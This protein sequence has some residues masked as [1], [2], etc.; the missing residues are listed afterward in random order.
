MPAILPS[1]SRV[2]P[3]RRIGT[4][5]ITRRLQF[6]L[7]AMALVAL[8]CALAATSCSTGL[9]ITVEPGYTSLEIDGDLGLTPS[10]GPTTPQ[11]IDIQEGFGLRESM[12]SP[13]GRVEVQAM[14]A[15]LQLS[16]FQIDQTGQGNL[17]VQFGDIPISTPIESTL[18]MTNLKAEV[19]FDL[20]DIG[21][22]RISPGLGVDYFDLKIDSFSLA[23]P[24]LRESLDAQAP[25][26][27]LFVQAEV[28]L[29][30][31]NFVADVGG[32]KADVEDAN[33][34]AIDI[35]V[36]ARLR[37][38]S[39]FEIFAGYRHIILDVEGKSDGQDYLGDLTISGFMVGGGIYF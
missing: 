16:G 1:P 10:V 23:V 4:S 12:D 20:I 5:R 13:F 24:T 7:R 2:C 22:V 14:I 27:M 11:R 8:V 36:L 35:E 31:V 34:T 15:R 18:E 33:G 28:D 29:G 26:P 19:L 37:P 38:F 25:I 30:V 3:P 17:A 9:G 32:M 6:R 39:N 21:P